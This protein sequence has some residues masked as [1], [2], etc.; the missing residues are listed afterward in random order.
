MKSGW[1]PMGTNFESYQEYA[2]GWTENF[3]PDTAAVKKAEEELTGLNERLQELETAYRRI[4]SGEGRNDGSR[5]AVLTKEMVERYVDKVLVY[6][7]KHIEILWK[8]NCG[9]E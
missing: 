9:A 2:D 3:Q 4:K 8:E 7:E 6:N 5:F 1:S